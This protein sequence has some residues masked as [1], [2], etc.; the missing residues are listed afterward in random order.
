MSSAPPGWYPD[1]TRPGF[2]RWWDGGAW[3]DVTRP[4]PGGGSEPA[5][6]QPYQQPYGA[7]PGYGA[8]VGK[9]L[10][11]G[12]PA[13]NPWRRLGGWFLDGI[14]VSIVTYL[15]GFAL[16][17]DAFDEFRRF[18]DQVQAATAAGTTQ[19][20]PTQLINNVLPTF[21]KLALLQLVV[22]AVYYI[23]LTKLYGSTLGKLATGIRVRPLGAEG[24]PSWGQ[25][26]VRFL[27]SDVIAAVPS[28]G[29][30]YFLI[31]SL[32]CLWDPQRQCL[33]DKIA[34]TGVVRRS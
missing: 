3:S 30:L 32:W 15:V 17:R 14:V 27:G 25:S 18:F 13:A 6:Q 26:V 11:D 20:D 19:P 23:P 16:V 7:Y 34:G 33:H 12:V 4:A 24:L 31:D 10:P 29:G 2:E 9:V 28:I 8:P 21:Y 22:G 1:V 5:A